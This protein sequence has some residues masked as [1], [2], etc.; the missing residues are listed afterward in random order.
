M[1]VFIS[2]SGERSKAIAT[3]L[4][5]WLPQVIQA[6]KPWMSDRSISPGA[7]WYV[8]LE[9]ALEACQYAIV[10]VT[11]ENSNAPW[12][13]FEAGALSRAYN[14]TRLTGTA[15]APEC[16]GAGSTF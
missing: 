12:L 7:S 13:M 2:W 3:I 10:C 4:T 5:N 1:N 9:R 11:P 16:D 6:L 15:A 14:K 8:E